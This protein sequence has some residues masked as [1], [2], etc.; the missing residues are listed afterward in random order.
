MTKE[1]LKAKITELYP[2]ATFDE[3]GEWL[4]VN[5]EAK[6]WQ[7]L[8]QQLRNADAVFFDYLFC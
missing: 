1:E 3:T 2:T 4:N 7:V 5:I 8:A 6:D